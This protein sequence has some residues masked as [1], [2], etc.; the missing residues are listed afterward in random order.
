[1]WQ[2]RLPGGRSLGRREAEDHL[3]RHQA[4]QDNGEDSKGPKT[5]QGVMSATCPET[6]G[7]PGALVKARSEFNFPQVERYCGV[8][9]SVTP[10]TTLSGPWSAGTH[11]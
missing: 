3:L 8:Q 1:M 9:A 4:K 6:Q 11:V 7:P 10:A 5:T 2:L